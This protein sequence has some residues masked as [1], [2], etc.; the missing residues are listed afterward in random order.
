MTTHHPLAEG[1]RGGPLVVVGTRDGKR[2][3]VTLP[4]IEVCR[5]AAVGCEFTIFGSVGREVVDER[6]R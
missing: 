1:E 2:W 3:R 4:E 5:R 6:P